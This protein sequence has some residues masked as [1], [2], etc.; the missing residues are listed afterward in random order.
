M[1]D[2]LYLNFTLKSTTVHPL[3]QG[4]KVIP[5]IK[6][7]TRLVRLHH[8]LVFAKAKNKKVPLYGTP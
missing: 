5:E 8:N 4:I 2:F 3:M 1:R 7:C 6:I